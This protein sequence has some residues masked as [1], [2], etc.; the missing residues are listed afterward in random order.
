MTYIITSDDWEKTDG[1]GQPMRQIEIEVGAKKIV[2]RNSE[3]RTKEELISF[4]EQSL[5][6]EIIFNTTGIDPREE[7]QE[8]AVEESATVSETATEPATTEQGGKT[9]IL[10]KIAGFFGFG[11]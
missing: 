2:A 10:G 8:P 4:I 3:C 5:V 11:S 1:C 7:S 6:P 9:S